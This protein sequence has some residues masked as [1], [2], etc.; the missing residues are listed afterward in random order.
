MSAPAPSAVVV[1]GVSGCGKTAV[2]EAL[3]RR[4]GARFV[5]ADDF[6]PPANV[7]KMRAGVPLDDA[8]RAPW[9][10]TLNALLRDEAAA[11]RPVV[12]ACSALRRRYRDALAEGVPGLRVV[13]LSGSF[14]LIASRLAARRHRYMPASLLRSQFEALEPPRE[15]VT[16]DVSGDVEAVVEAALRGLGEGAP[17]G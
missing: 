16:V 6:H 4:L 9:L 8:D 14:E 13:H 3:A 17:R 1:M 15:A 7:E 11:R 5:D 10:A 12:L 2:G